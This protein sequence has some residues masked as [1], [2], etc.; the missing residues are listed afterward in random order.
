METRTVTVLL[1]ISSLGCATHA[2]SVCED[3]GN[4][5]T[6]SSDQIQACQKQAKQLAA[7][8]SS[9]GCSSQFE[10]YF[11]CADDHYECK[12]NVPTFLGCESARDALDTCLAQARANNSCGALS[13]LLALCPGELPPASSAPPAPCSAAEVCSSRC[14]LSSVADVCRPEPLQLTQAGRCAQLCPL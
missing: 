4:C 2:D 7:E 5:T 14:Y 13:M 1:A 8:A 12:G 10:R 11:S 9:S 6:E 3:I